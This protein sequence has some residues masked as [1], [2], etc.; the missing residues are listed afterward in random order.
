MPG[1]SVA[2]SPCPYDL[3]GLLASLDRYPYGCTEQTISRALPL[4]YVSEL[5]AGPGQPAVDDTLRD[6]IQD[7]VQRVL[8]RQRADG[9]FG[10]WSARDRGDPWISA[11]ALDFLDRARTAGYAVDGLAL[12]RSRLYFDAMLN[13]N[14]LSDEEMEAAAYGLAVLAR[15]NAV[16]PGTVR[17]FIE[18]RLKRVD[19]GMGRA[20]V[21]LAA[22]AFGFNDGADAALAA[23]IPALGGGRHA[24]YGSD[25]RDAA[26]LVSVAAALNSDVLRQAADRL[27][28]LT[29]ADSYTSTQ[30]KAWMVVAGW[31][32]RRALV[33]SR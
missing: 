27:R 25:L 4:L 9:S 7:A 18:A 17:H 14:S 10:L 23:A 11:Y 2:L 32:L 29:I 16:E 22:A 26:A 28:E 20:Q 5:S 21:A 24:S 3:H 8:S 19:S 30:E 1:L 13:R 33:A 12:Q 15:G 6:R 31:E